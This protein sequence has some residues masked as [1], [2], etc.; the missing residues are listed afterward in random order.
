MPSLKLKMHL[1]AI[2][3]VF[4]LL[5]LLLIKELASN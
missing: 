4:F 2:S 1:L 3:E 5:F